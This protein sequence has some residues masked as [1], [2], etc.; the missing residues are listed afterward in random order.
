MKRSEVNGYIREAITFFDQYQFR[1]P[2]FA[3]W[4]P[5]DWDGIG[6]EAAEIRDN[7]L[8]WDITDFGSGQF[9]KMGLFLFTLRNGNPNDKK[10]YPKSYAEKIMIVREEQ[11]TPYHFHWQKMEDIINRGGG[12]LIVRLYP[13]TED[14]QLGDKDLIVHL[15][16]VAK[17]I[18]AGDIVKLRPGESITLM[19]YQYHSFWAEKGSGAVL[20]GEVSHVNDDNRDNRFL[21][22]LQRFSDIEEDEKPIHFLVSD[23]TKLS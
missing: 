11:V 23:Y 6:D 8:G 14:E 5:R 3:Y 12:N 2:P 1:L 20:T 16:G 18:Q 7:M 4:T 10:K 22:P 21:Q 15:D 19:P 9:E 17:T 13:S